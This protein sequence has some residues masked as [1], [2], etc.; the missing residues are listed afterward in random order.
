MKARKQ[1]SGVRLV[2]GTTTDGAVVSWGDTE[3]R[4]GPHIFVSGASGSGKSRFLQ[5]L[6]RQVI[7]QHAIKKQGMLA[8]DP[9]GELVG[10][11]LGH[12]AE[13]PELANVPIILID[14]TDGKRLVPYNFLLPR[15]G[16]DPAVIA[17]NIVEGIAHA[18]GGASSTQTPRLA[19]VAR[20]LIQ[21]IYDG[22]RTLFDILPLLDHG[23]S[24]LRDALIR[25]LP[26]STAREF[27]GQLNSLGK[28]EFDTVVESFIN[29]MS[30]L[31]SKIWPGS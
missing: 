13:N 25:D 11:V 3:T 21:G 4:V 23:N 12:I 2:F 24:A 29:R 31:R 30:S 6:V 10:G 27:L 9:H 7:D 20:A 28:R 15:P 5:S 18:F 8:I 16:V 14:S 19:R 17:H 26:E 1:Y 22:G